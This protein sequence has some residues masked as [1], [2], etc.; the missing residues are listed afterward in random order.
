[1]RVRILMIKYLRVRSDNVLA[2]VPILPTNKLKHSMVKPIY[3]IYVE[4]VSEIDFNIK[5]IYSK[6]NSVLYAI[7]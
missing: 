2:M 3:D 4:S 6:I 7:L 5:I 1:M